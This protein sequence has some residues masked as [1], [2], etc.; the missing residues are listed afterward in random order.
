MVNLKIFKNEQNDQ[1]IAS[2]E[3][4]ATRNETKKNICFGLRADNSNITNDDI[5]K[6][7]TN[8]AVELLSDSDS[9][10]HFND[11]I[12]DEQSQFIQKLIRSFVDAFHSEYRK[13]SNDFKNKIKSLSGK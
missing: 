8:L 1:I 3:N 2:I 7:L 13:Q 12:D 9:D 6:F 11:K 10:I 4:T 5:A